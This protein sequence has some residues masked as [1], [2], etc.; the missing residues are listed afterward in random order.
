MNNQEIAFIIIATLTVI[1]FNIINY[2]VFEYSNHNYSKYGYDLFHP[3]SQTTQFITGL[4]YGIMVIY[5]LAKLFI[6]LSD[7]IDKVNP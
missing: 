2:L 1:V 3:I 6:W 7:Y 4:Y 5:I